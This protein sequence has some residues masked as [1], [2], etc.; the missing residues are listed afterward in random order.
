MA[1][2]NTIVIPYEELD[3]E[4]LT[5]EE[6][7]DL[8]A[9]TEA[10]R[11]AY[12]PYSHF[13][14]GASLRMKDGNTAIGW[15]VENVIYE[16]LHAEANALGRVSPQSRLSG[17]QRVTTIGGF[18]E[19]DSETIASP[20]G[21]CRQNLLEVVGPEDNPVVIMAGIRGKV[22]RAGLKDLLPFAFYPALLK[23]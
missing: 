13:L 11:N 17:L 16:A 2:H 4:E 20:C 3:R 5:P 6:Y 21:L 8:D 19:S 7:F 15:N 12:A 22:I 10:R 9:A 14:C 23:R 1:R 18:E